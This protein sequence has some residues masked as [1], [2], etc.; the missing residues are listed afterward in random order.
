MSSQRKQKDKKDQKAASTYASVN[1]Q[2]TVNSLKEILIPQIKE[3]QA[4]IMVDI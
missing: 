3:T 1:T 2:S 4:K